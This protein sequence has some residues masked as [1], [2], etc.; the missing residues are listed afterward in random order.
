MKKNSKTT[1]KNSK[2]EKFAGVPSPQ[3][4]N[5]VAAYL[6]EQVDYKLKEIQKLI[7]D[8][9]DN[10]KLHKNRVAF[11]GGFM[12][13]LDDLNNPGEYTRNMSS[14]NV[15]ETF[16]QRGVIAQVTRR[17]DVQDDKRDA[18]NEMGN[19]LGAL[20][21]NPGKNSPLTQALEGP[22]N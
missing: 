12:V 16:N 2:A 15:G 7:G 3:S 4:Q 20:F 1:K 18:D 5:G 17:T 22:K 11:A 8:A 19:I 10:G 14:L 6:A 9:I 21:G 13:V